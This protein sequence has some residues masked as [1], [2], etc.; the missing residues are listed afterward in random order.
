MGVTGRQATMAFGVYGANSWGVATSVTRRVYFESDA[1]LT[2]RPMYVDD[3][4]F[5][6]TFMGPAD[7]GDFE[8]VAFTGSGQLYYDHWDMMLMACAMG[9]PAVTAVSSQGASNSLVAYQHVYDLAPTTQG[10]GVTIAS[11]KVQYVEEVRSAKVTGFSF[12]YGNGGVLTKS[13]S[14]IGDKSN[15]TSAINTRSSVTTSAV[16][17]ALTNRVFRQQGQIRMNLQAG[18]SLGSGDVLADVTGMSFTF[19]RPHDTAM[20]TGQ[21]YTAEPLDNGWPAVEV[22]LNFRQATTISTNSFYALVQAG[23]PLKADCTYTGASINS[24]TARMVK[25]EFPHLEPQGPLNFTIQ[26]ASQSQPSIRFV[27]KLASAAPSGMSGVTN[28]VRVTL[29]TVNSVTAF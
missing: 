17:P 11:D 25:L 1:G 20:V 14:F 10:R 21:N 12:G 4:S 27:G 5:G 13:F 23:T 9:S 6:Q 15:N 16:A 2:S 28:P 24:A 26:G 22:T 29:N 7:V 3:Q 8:P 18:S 19:Q